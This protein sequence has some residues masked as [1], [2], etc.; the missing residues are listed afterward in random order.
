M[1]ERTLHLRTRTVR[2]LYFLAASCAL[3]VAGLTIFVLVGLSS[4]PTA[5]NEL[6][7]R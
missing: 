1:S 6:P 2:V 5:T 7:L 4:M 3:I